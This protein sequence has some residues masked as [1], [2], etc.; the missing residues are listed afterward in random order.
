MVQ[1]TKKA[2]GTW[3]YDYEIF[4]KYVNLCDEYGIN[5][6]INC[7]SMV[8]WDMSFRYWDEASNAYQT[9]KTTTGTQEYRDLWTSFLTAFKAHLQEKGWFE[10][11]NIAMDERAEADMLNA[12]NIANALGFNMALAGN[13]HS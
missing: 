3:A 12:Y 8:P 10:K 4:D 7:F 1:T 5:K 13:Y 9:I 6:Q 2:D 11:T